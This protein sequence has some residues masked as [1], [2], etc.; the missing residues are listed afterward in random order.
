MFLVTIRMAN[1]ASFKKVFTLVDKDNNPVSLAG[2]PLRCWIKKNAGDSQHLE[3][4]TTNGYL[5]VDSVNTNKLTMNIPANALGPT[6]QIV[7]GVEVDNPYVFDL[8]Q[9][10]SATDRPLI[11]KGTISV[12]RGVTHG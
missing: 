8:L 5:S 3:L 2:A 1:N 9:I 4:S 7:R 11:L 12:D 6:K 10:N